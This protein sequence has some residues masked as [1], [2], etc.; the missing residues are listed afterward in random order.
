MSADNGI[1]IL[2]TNRAPNGKLNG[3]K[4]Y[5]VR[6]LQAI[7]NLTYDPFAPDPILPTSNEYHSVHEYRP[8]DKEH[9]DYQKAYRL[10]YHSDNLDVHIHNARHMWRDCFVFSRR[11]DALEYAAD[12][13]ADL[14]NIYPLEYYLR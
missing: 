7:E 3:K 14:E 5:R 9:C 6:E 13:A 10:K 4:Q 8:D 1:Y 11:A 12:Y 2:V